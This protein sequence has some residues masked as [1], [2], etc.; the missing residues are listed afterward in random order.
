[1]SLP[2]WQQTQ[3][4]EY[5]NWECL[6]C[7]KLA[8]SPAALE[9]QHLIEYGPYTDINSDKWIKCDECFNP[10]HVECLQEDIPV[11]KYMCTFLGCHK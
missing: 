8:Q 1:M 6:I 4:A 5:F 10:Y 7:S 9:D 2:H 3:G 11:S